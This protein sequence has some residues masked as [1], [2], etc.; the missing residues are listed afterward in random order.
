MEHLPK[1]IRAVAAGELRL[2]NLLNRILGLV[3]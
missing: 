2:T 3:R 1:P